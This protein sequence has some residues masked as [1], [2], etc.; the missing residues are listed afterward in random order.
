[1]SIKLC[2]VCQNRFESVEKDGV[3][4]YAC[5]DCGNEVKSD[6]FIVSES[7]KSIGDIFKFNP[8]RKY[9]CALLRTMKKCVKCDEIRELVIVKNLY[10]MQNVFQCVECDHSWGF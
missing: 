3:L 1:M 2:N 8:L 4:Y 5:H 9:D 10:N 6:D 7:G